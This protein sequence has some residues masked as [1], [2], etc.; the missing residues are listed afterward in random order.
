MRTTQLLVALVSVSSI[1]SAWPW[2]N[3]AIEAHVKRGVENLIYGRQDE[4]TSQTRSASDAQ[5][6]TSPSASGSAAA[7]KSA[8]DSK[9]A[10]ITS[11]P[12]GSSR[13][14][15]SASDSG[16]ASKTDS[17]ASQTTEYDPRLPAGG[18]EMVKPGRF[19]GQQ[20]YK[21][22]E[23]VTFKW[24]YTSLSAT[25]TAIDV[26]ASCSLNQATYTL[27]SNMTTGP[28]GEVVWDTKQYENTGTQELITEKYTLII[29]DAA[30]AITAIPKPGYLGLFS[31]F[32]FG[33]YQKQDYKDLDEF[34]CATCLNSGAL[35][36][37]E[38][39]TLT[40][41][42]TVAFV[43]MLSFT[44]FATGRFGIF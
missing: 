41:M 24:N 28:T 16:S 8:P 15:G 14:S 19:D 38:R 34:Q 36:A 18:I 12:S 39:Q 26:L 1:A 22:G 20:Y 6:T 2:P 21:I 40:T 11:S 42:L 5:E 29:Y 23:Y 10:S 27:T 33:M 30:S 9:T 17:D 31:S 37:M 43:T 25:P 7:S 32:T 13:P 44:F 35:T 4:S 3:K